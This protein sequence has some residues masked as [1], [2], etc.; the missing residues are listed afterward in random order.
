MKIRRNTSDARLVHRVSISTIIA[1]VT[2]TFL[3]TT[4]AIITALKK[5]N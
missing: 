3:M 4:V 5:D 1:Q 2:I